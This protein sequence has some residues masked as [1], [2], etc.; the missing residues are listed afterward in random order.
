MRA[1]ILWG[2]LPMEEREAGA[3][4]P[5]VVGDCVYLSISLTQLE[6]NGSDYWDPNN[7]EI[8]TSFTHVH[9]GN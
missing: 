4:E 7:P 2:Y 1:K 6:Q 8:N 5:K 3:N 9:Q